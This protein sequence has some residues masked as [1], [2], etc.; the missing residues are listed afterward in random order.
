VRFRQAHVSL[1][2][3]TRGVSDDCSGPEL[4]HSPSGS[5]D[6]DAI[7]LGVGTAS[8]GTH[9]ANGKAQQAGGGHG[10]DAAACHDRD[11][12]SLA[13]VQVGHQVGGAS[14]SVPQ[15]QG[16]EGVVRHRCPL[17][18]KV[19]PDAPARAQASQVP[20]FTVPAATV[21]DGEPERAHQ[22]VFVGYAPRGHDHSGDGVVHDFFL[23]ADGDAATLAAASQLSNQRVATPV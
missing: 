1:A 5:D 2:P 23:R 7:E 6:G 9:L 21:I 20:A 13:R 8:G 10:T 18:G 3:R 11:D 22:M 12:L 16:I 15:L 17:G 4:T 14:E 19:E